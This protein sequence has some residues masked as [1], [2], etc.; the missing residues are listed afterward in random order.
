MVKHANA[1][2]KGSVHS[3]NETPRSG[4]AKG[5]SAK[6]FIIHNPS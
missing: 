2:L 5:A 6:A 1:R 3:L 4:G